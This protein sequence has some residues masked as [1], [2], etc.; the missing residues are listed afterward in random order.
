MWHS[1]TTQQPG[2]AQWHLEKMHSG[3]KLGKITMCKCHDSLCY[4]MEVHGVQKMA[5]INRSSNGWLPGR[6]RVCQNLDN[7]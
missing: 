4:V 3:V 1:R 5:A 6:G 7:G 2:R